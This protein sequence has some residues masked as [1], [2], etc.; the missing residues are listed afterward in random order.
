MPLRKG[1]ALVLATTLLPGALGAGTLTATS[2]MFALELEG[3]QVGWLHSASGGDPSKAEISAKEGQYFEVRRL[4]QTKYDDLTI[5]AGM[6]QAVGDWIKAAWEDKGVRKN[7]AVLT[8][9]SNLAILSRKEF[10]GVLSE[11]TVP[12]LDVADKGPAHLTLK[13]A[14]EH[15]RTV[16]GSGT[17]T[18]P[19]GGTTPWT[20]NNF[21]LDI[22][23]LDCSH[24]QRIDAMTIATPTVSDQTGQDKAPTLIPGKTEFPHVDITLS[25]A[26]WDS[27]SAWFQ[28]ILTLGG[29]NRKG[30][31]ARLPRSR[32]DDG[33]WADPILGPRGRGDPAHESG[34]GRRGIQGAALLQPHGL[35]VESRDTLI[36]HVPPWGSRAG[37]VVV[38]VAT[39]PPLSSGR[40]RGSHR[41]V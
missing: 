17:A 13:V 39:W 2:G 23:G 6:S 9:N 41:R 32:Q 7:G 19:K 12:A 15:S 5:Q 11:T 35:R 22:P 37:R 38:S 8:C 21:R 4:S 25:D 14:L 36:R 34:G 1:W 28:P 20:V 31:D 26:S 29:E 40:R 3:T 16:A 33:A 18:A 27:W 30:W 24:V 10:S